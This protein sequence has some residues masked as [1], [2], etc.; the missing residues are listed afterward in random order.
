MYFLVWILINLWEISRE[1]DI[2]INGFSP[3]Q[4]SLESFLN[5]HSELKSSFQLHFKLMFLKYLSREH[6]LY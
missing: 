2:K 5:I 6:I 4:I 1:S 3:W